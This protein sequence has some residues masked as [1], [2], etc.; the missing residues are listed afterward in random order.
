ML[1]KLYNEQS[2]FVPEN[3]HKSRL[4]AVRDIAF[5]VIYSVICYC[6]GLSV[7]YLSF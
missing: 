7:V 6:H 2:S 3:L 1:D 4:E 5:S